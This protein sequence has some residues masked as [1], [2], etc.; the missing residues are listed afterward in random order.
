MKEY[1]KIQSIYKRD[2]KTHRFIEGDWSLPE[3]EYLKDNSWVWT[4]KI[5]GTNIR[6]MWD[7]E[8]VLFGGKTDNAQVPTFLLTKLQELFPVSKFAELY[9]ETPMC[10]YG[11]GYGARIQK[12]GGKYI[13]DGVDFILFDVVIDGWWLKR[14]NVEDIAQ[15][16]GIKVVP[17]I[18][19]G[20]IEEAISRVK[21]G[22]KSTFGDFE[23]EGLV[24]KPKVELFTRAGHRVITKLKH[25]DFV[26]ELEE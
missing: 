17:I 2:E 14:E 13:P 4:E 12:R 3:F 9:P 22:I 16:L 10:I 8:R 20:T 18:G 19:E 24:L 6:T 26:V 25:K 23:A 5:N 15:K 7:G 21:S 1:P 11:E